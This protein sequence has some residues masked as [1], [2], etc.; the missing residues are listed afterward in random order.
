[1]GG[2]NAFATVEADISQ[3]FAQ[4]LVRLLA[5][6]GRHDRPRH[7]VSVVDSRRTADCVST[8]RTRLLK[9]AQM[10]ARIL[11]ISASPRIVCPLLGSRSEVGRLAPSSRGLGHGPFKAATRVRIP[12]GSIGKRNR[13]ALFTDRRRAVFLFLMLCSMKWLKRSEKTRIGMMSPTGMTSSSAS[14]GA[15]TTAGGAAR[16]AP[17]ARAEAGDA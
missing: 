6:G 13:P 4:T 5:R 11:M 17:I 15:S 10:I 16:R 14:R 3:I 1:M 12:L 2:G 7:E 9:T 8:L